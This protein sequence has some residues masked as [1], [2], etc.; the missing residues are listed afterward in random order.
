LR[1]LHIW[2][3]SSFKSVQS[4]E[5]F[6]LLTLLNSPFLFLMVSLTPKCTSG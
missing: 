1:Q 2:E 3:K 5:I 6:S 4:Y